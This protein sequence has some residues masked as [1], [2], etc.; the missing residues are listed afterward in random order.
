MAVKPQVFVRN[1]TGLRKE[2]GVFDV[3]VYNVN[4]QNIGLGVVFLISVLGAYVGGNFPLSAILGSLL[5][6]PLYFV[7]SK[8]SADIAR[9][10]GDYV[11][12]SRIFGPTWGPLVGFTLAWTWIMLA[13]TAIGAPAAFFA[14]YG[15]APWMRS[16]GWRPVAP[17]SRASA[18]G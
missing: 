10:G 7:Y 11:W 8:F 2:A 15:V 4:N 5:V 6:V 12:T 1:S 18:T 17:R 14:T 9:S 3:F 13:F 16:L